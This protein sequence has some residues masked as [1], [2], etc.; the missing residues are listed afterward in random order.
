MI[1]TETTQRRT[2]KKVSEAKS[3]AII[4]QKTDIRFRNS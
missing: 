4:P 2:T 3:I 1:A